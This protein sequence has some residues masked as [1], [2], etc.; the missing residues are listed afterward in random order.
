MPER[1]PVAYGPPAHPLFAIELITDTAGCDQS[2]GSGAS[3]WG[4]NQSN[5]VRCGEEVYALSWRDDLSLVVFRRVGPGQWEHSPPTPPVPQN[6]NL[7]VDQSGCLHLIGG[8]E[9]SF[10]AVFEPPGQVRHFRLRQQARADSRFGAASEN[11]RIFVAGGLERLGWYLLDAGLDCRPLLS[12]EL[13]H[14]AARGYHFVALQGGAAHAF[15]SDDHFLAGNEYPNQ[16]VTYRDAA[17]GQMKTVETPHGIYPVLKSYYYYCPD[18]MHAPQDWRLQVVSD[19]SDTFA[20]GKRGTTEQQDLL[21]DAQGRVHLIYFENR[22]PSGTVWA[23]TGQDQ[24]HSRLYHAVGQP[25]GPLAHYYLGNFNSGRL[26]QTP[27][28]RMHY[29]LTRGWRGDAESLWYAV[30]AED[31]GRTSEPV[32]LE[33]PTRFW[34]FFTNTTRAGGTQ[35]PF[36]D[37]YWTGAYQRD[38]HQVWFGRLDP[39]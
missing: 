29:L 28:G 19:V 34:H 18:L 11:D 26:Y 16:V 35:A 38:S 36:I 39:E 31:W 9:A 33:I 3:C 37:C 30:G 17:T 1:I 22:Q 5:I 27:D 15:C 13:R 21:L 6:G 24:E 4:Y 25:D 8:A 14:E 12:G 20:D 7:L 2:G 23:A 32:P 10:Q